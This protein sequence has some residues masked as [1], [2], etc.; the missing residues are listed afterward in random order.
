MHWL[1]KIAFAI[2]VAVFMRIT[3]LI[4]NS[5]ESIPDKSLLITIMW[6]FVVK[7]LLN[8]GNKESKE[9]TYKC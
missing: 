6:I 4:I 5:S 1:E 9:V 2:S 7:F 8:Y 3:I